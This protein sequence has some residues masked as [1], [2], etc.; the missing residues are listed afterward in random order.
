M[1]LAKL[2]LCSSLTQNHNQCAQKGEGGGWLREEPRAAAG[3]MAALTKLCFCLSS[4]AP[5]LTFGWGVEEQ[6][7]LDYLWACYEDITY[8]GLHS[9]NQLPVEISN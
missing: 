7:N 1:R 8:H 2:P 4:W 9:C 3:G 5:P 6:K